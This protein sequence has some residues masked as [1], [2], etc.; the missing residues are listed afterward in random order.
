MMAF[1]SHEVVPNLVPDL[2]RDREIGPRRGGRGSEEV[3]V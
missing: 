3:D 2:I 1:M